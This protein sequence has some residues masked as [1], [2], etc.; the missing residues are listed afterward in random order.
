MSRNR[1]SDRTRFTA[2]EAK[3]Y[4][5]AIHFGDLTAVLRAYEGRERTKVV[6]ADSEAGRALDVG[7][8]VTL[9]E[10]PAGRVQGTVKRVLYEIDVDLTSHEDPPRREKP[11]PMFE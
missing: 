4:E 3:F 6:V 9:G 11:L 1:L 5:G 10:H 2:D 7:E 8:N